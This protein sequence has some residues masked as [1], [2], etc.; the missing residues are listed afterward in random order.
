MQSTADAVEQKAMFDKHLVVA[1]ADAAKMKAAF[2]KVNLSNQH[3]VKCP[4]SMSHWFAVVCFAVGCGR[5]RAEGTVRCA[6]GQGQC[7]CLRD[8]GCI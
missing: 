3:A 2:D 1:Q 8:E 6:A 5:G 7:R 4:S